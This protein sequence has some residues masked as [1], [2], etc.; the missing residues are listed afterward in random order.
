MFWGEV[1]GGRVWFEGWEV[2]EEGGRRDLRL[3]IRSQRSGRYVVDLGGRL[4][5]EEGAEAGL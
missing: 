3:K 2:V 4:S 5:V 1:E